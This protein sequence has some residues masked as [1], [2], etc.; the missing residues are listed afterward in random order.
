VAGF[1]LRAQWAFE[2]G[3]KV[4]DIVEVRWTNSGRYL[5]GKAKVTKLNAA[6]LRAELLEEVRADFG[7]WP[8]G[9]SLT[10]PLV[11]GSIGALSRWSANN[12]VFPVKEG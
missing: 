12:G 4:G 1:D 8:A 3:L 2:Q 10:A 5:S 9:Q 11:S 7:T 6:S